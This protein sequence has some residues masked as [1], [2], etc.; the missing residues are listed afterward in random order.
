MLSFTYLRNNTICG[1]VIA[2]IIID[3]KH[4]HIHLL[5]QVSYQTKEEK[6]EGGGGERR[7]RGIVLDVNSTK[8]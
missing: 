1:C 2:N 8:Y 3:F 5:L 6:E 4:S 7:R